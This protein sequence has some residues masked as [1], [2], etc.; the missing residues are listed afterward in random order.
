M[1]TKKPVISVILDDDVLKE[2]EDYQYG[3][4]IPSRS[5]ALNDII[6]LGIEQLRKEEKKGEGE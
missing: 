1:A 2:V 3:K 5:K 4:R 6:K